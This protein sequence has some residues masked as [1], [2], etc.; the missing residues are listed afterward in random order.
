MFHRHDRKTKSSHAKP[1]KDLTAIV[2]PSQLLSD[3][4]RQ[5]LL[6]KMMDSS[7]LESSRFDSVGLSLINNLINHCQRMPETTNSYYALPGGLLDH[8][9]NR[10]EAAL[11]LFRQFVVQEEGALL[12]EEQ[13][14][15]LYA[16]FSAGI[17][18]G[19]GKLQID[20][21]VDLFDLNGQLLK[22]WSPLLESMAS[23]GSYYQFEFQP[24]GE[25]NL[26][27]RLN[28]L[29]AR[30]LIPASGFAWII[31][32]PHVLAVWL[33]LL[34]E[35]VR[36]AGT[37]GAILIRADGIAIQR[38]F[39]EFMGKGAGHQIG[40]PTRMNTFIDTIPE[41]V[42]EKERIVGVEF[43][44]W[45]TNKLASGQI[46]INKAPLFMVPGGLLMSTEVYK[47]FVREH[48][49]FKNWQAAQSAFLSL[50]LHS[51]SADG[52][53]VS[54]F[55]QANTQQIHSGDLFEQYAVALP[56]EVPVQIH[57]LHTGEVTS[58]SATDLVHMAQFNNH[59]FHHQEHSTN[60]VSL[61]HLSQ[62]GEWQ[63]VDAKSISLQ[64]GNKHRG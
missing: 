6:Q 60:P 50:G 20:Y 11:D 49:E 17:L 29:L 21:R 19:V 36:G 3:S 9:L 61:N 37:L 10:T 63:P 53:T 8:A 35:D 40:R 52:S 59:S 28:I 27:C 4:R 13:K 46:M 56:A 51:V 57:N 38:Y 47:W 26:R 25:D 24:E 23:I 45:L 18:Q 15:W 48:P 33:A 14:L 2:S 22:Q 31:S 34:S 39:N 55:E 16:L 44:K 30:Q 62:S 58:I 41:S 12:S 42:V 32:N 54:R 5:E 43:I 64:Q 7:G 1:L